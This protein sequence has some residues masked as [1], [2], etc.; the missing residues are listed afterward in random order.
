[1]SIIL[2]T[3][4]LSFRS[5]IS[6]RRSVC[7]ICSDVAILCGVVICTT[8]LTGW[9][10]RPRTSVFLKIYIVSFRIVCNFVIV[11]VRGCLGTSIVVVGTICIISC[12]VFLSF[13]LTTLILIVTWFFTMVARWSGLVRVFTVGLVASQCLW[14]FH[15]ELPNHSLLTPFQD[16]TRSVHTCHFPDAPGYMISSAA[17]AFWHR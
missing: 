3:L 4:V 9:K 15:L 2:L 7:C 14:A 13:E 6:W 8:C 16:A 11:G 1:M 17:E 12:L 10:D 5:S